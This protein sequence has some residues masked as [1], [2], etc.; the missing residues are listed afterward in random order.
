MPRR[1]R[2]SALRNHLQTSVLNG[3]ATILPGGSVTAP[4][5]A[6]RMFSG[7]VHQ[8][9]AA[10]NVSYSRFAETIGLRG[11]H[12]DSPDLMASAWEQALASEI[13][14]VLEVKT[15]P[16][17]PPLPP[18]I[19]LQQARNLSIALI[20]GD[21][22]EVGAIRGAARHGKCLRPSCRGETEADILCSLFVQAESSSPNFRK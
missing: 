4:P 12:I 18:H 20:K 17:V 5:A 13:P 19:T 9:Y 15:D 21:P 11:I 14:V 22:N 16:E 1:V 7:A 10:L 6:L 8:L 3:K 2:L